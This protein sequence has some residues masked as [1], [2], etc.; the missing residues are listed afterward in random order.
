MS[1]S[2]SHQKNHQSQVCYL[3]HIVGSEGVSTDPA[4]IDAVKTWAKPSTI[5]D[6]KQFLGFCFY[7]RKLVPGFPEIAH[8][9]NSLTRR[10]NQGTATFTWTAEAEQSFQSLK[11]HLTKAPI[12][13][14]PN[15]HENLI[16]DTDASNFGFGAVLSQIQNGQERVI[17]YYGRA[18]NQSEKHYCATRKELLA[19]IQVIKHFHPYAY[20]RRFL[21][22]TD[23][24]A[25]TWLLNFKH[26]EGQLARWIEFLQT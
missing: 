23:H 6:V 10:P 7:Y 24:A 22:R 26:Q 11:E 21:V 2:N 14:Y 18:L 9:F 4:K 16:I 15:E 25:L 5:K 17:S 8:P 3:G 1:T 19:V 20:G 12:L 13:G